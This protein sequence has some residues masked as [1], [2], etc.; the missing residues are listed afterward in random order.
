MKIVIYT[1]KTC[2]KCEKVKGYLKELGYSYE[3]KFASDIENRDFLVKNSVKV[4][5]YLVV[6]ENDSSRSNEGY[7]DK[8][9]LKSFIENV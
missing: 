1:L 5:P 9:N 6:E 7:I 4:A 3:E 8:D 2:P